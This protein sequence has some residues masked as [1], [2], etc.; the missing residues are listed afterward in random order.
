M[1]FTCKD[2][3]QEISRLTEVPKEVPDDICMTCWWIRSNEN[4]TEEEKDI[5][6]GKFINMK[7]HG[8]P[9]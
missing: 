4:L 6:R 5:L 9:L 2:C 8:S 7:T 1:I 3:G